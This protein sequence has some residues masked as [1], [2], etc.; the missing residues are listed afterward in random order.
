[1]AGWSARFAQALVLFVLT[2]CC[3]CVSDPW[4]AGTEIHSEA[5]GH[6][7]LEQRLWSE[8][9]ALAAYTWR[10]AIGEDCPFPFLLGPQTETSRPI[11]LV[12][13]EDWDDTGVGRYFEDWG[14]EILETEQLVPEKRYAMVETIMHEL[15]HAMAGG[16]HSDDARDLMAASGGHLTE[17]DVARMREALGCE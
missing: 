5:P 10:Q 15:G 1:M 16:E 9:V 13:E 6:T 12:R 8:H 14:I 4:S 7:A 3:A 17:H 11:R 2:G